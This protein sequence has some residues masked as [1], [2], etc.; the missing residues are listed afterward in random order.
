MCALQKPLEIGKIISMISM[1]SGIFPTIL[2]PQM[3]SMSEQPIISGSLYYNCKGFFSIVLI[4]ICDYRYAFT[5]LDIGDYGLNND[6]GVFSKSAIGKKLFNKEMNLLNPEFLKNS[7]A[8][9]QIPYYLVDD[10]VFSL[11]QWVIKRY[12]G[13]RIQGYF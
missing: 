10:D 6:S 13:Q 3:A 9:C 2:D 4:A 8:I 7:Y 12:P 11:Q 1:R 5:F